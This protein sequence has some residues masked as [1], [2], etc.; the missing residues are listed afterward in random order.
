MIDKWQTNYSA[1]RDSPMYKRATT[2]WTMA[3]LWDY[4]TMNCE[5]S[6]RPSYVCSPWTEPHSSTNICMV[7]SCF[8]D[9]TMWKHHVAWQTT[10]ATKTIKHLHHLQHDEHPLHSDWSSWYY[11]IRALQFTTYHHCKNKYVVV[12][13]KIIQISSINHP[14]H[15]DFMRFSWNLRGFSWDCASAVLRSPSAMPGKFK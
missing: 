5:V 8:L 9:V 13:S 3:W 7:K 15:P 2:I 4:G 10:R 1:I 12:S 6:A 11:H 14:N